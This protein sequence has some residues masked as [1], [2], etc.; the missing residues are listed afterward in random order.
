MA[1]QPIALSLHQVHNAPPVHLRGADV[2][3]APPTGPSK[4]HRELLSRRLRDLDQFRARKG[5]VGVGA[6][7]TS[8]KTGKV[9]AVGQQV[10]V[11]GHTG[12]VSHKHEASGL[13]VIKWSEEKKPTPN[14][15]KALTKAT[16]SPTPDTLARWRVARTAMNRRKP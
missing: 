3:N 10:S 9:H 15:P 7:W 4:E 11:R 13:P 2:H 6:Q 16:T 12:T 1:S 8:R 14:E 5:H